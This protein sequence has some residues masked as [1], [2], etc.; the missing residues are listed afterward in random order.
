MSLSDTSLKRPVAM[1]CLLIALAFL[2]LNAYRKMGLELMPKVDVPYISILTVWPGA[3]PTDIEIDVAKKIEDA[4]SGVD[5]LKHVSSTCMENAVQTSLEFELGT[6]VDVAANDVREKVDQ[7]LSELPEDVEKPVIQK[8][9]VNAQPVVTLA[10]E[11]DLP[12]D[13]L[14]DYADQSLRDR[15]SVLA[16]VAEVKLTGGAKREVHVLL[17]RETLAAAGLTTLQ[18]EQALREGVRTLPAGRVRQHGAEYSVR[19]DAEYH[20]VPDIGSLQVVGRDG[21]R[22]YLRDLGTVRLGTEERRQ[23]VFLDGKPAVALRIVKKADAP[24]DRCGR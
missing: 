7:K 20:S 8:F 19:Y 2:G 18:V 5:G 12:L 10:L 9:N 6:D 14:Y 11:G 21:A 13:E 17:D 3:S 22:R 24:P 4:V 15:F 1:G 23:A 16:G